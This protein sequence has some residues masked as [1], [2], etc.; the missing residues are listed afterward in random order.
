MGR[1][2]QLLIREGKGCETREKQ[3]G[4]TTGATLE[5]GLIPQQG[6]HTTIPLSCSADTEIPSSW[7]KL[8]VNNQKLSPSTYQFES[9]G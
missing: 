1:F 7:E 2:K 5:Q 6:I 8:T 4:G 9:E 3:S